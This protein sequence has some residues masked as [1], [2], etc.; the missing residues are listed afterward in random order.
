[1]DFQPQKEFVSYAA[2]IVGEDGKTRFTIPFSPQASQTSFEVS[3]YAGDLRSGS[4]SMFIRARGQNGD[5][6]EL[7][8]GY[9]KV[10]FRD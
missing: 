1:M 4:Y 6:H 8:H 2:Q 5:E 7:A 9:F 3:L 10:Q